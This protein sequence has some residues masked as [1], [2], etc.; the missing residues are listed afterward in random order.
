MRIVFVPNTL[1]QTKMGSITGVVY[2]DFGAE[3]QFPVAGWNDFVVVIAGWWLAEVN[4]TVR[5]RSETVLRFMDGPYGVTVVP[6]EDSTVLL[7]CTADR[8]GARVVHEAIVSMDDLEREVASL[9]RTVSRACASAGIKS[10]DLD[11][12]RSLLPN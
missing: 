5:A 6:Q 4:K 10:A 11:E 1:H 2:F 3:N 8:V 12:L 7:R 9:A